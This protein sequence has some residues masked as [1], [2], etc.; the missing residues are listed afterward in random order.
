MSAQ[1]APAAKTLATPGVATFLLDV[2][3]AGNSQD[4]Y[5]ATIVGTSGPVTAS[6]VGLDGTPTQSIASFNLPALGTGALALDATISSAGQGTVTVVV[7]SL[8]T[9]QE[10]T[11]VASISAA[12]GNDGP[13]VTL[14]QRYGIH[15]DRTTLVLTF[16]Q[17]LDPTRATNVHEYRLLDWEGHVVPIVSAVYDPT[18]YTVTLHPKGASTSTTLTH[19]S[20]KGS[21]R[22]GSPAQRGCCLTAKTQASPAATT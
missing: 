12:A 4:Q 20:L 14:V 9:G 16:D 3:N 19:C 1:F 15:M 13:K 18:T 2:N 5:S 8:T 17:P 21:G 10:T 22:P 7:K 6:L 11:L